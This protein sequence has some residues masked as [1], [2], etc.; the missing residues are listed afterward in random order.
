MFIILVNMQVNI[1]LR[2]W[3]VN[4]TL[5][6]LLIINDEHISVT[7]TD[8]LKVGNL[9]RCQKSEGAFVLVFDQLVD[10]VLNDACNNH[11]QTK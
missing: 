11:N 4:Q 7:F 6:D 9:I 3:K 2:K 8:H 1:F 10:H 5:V